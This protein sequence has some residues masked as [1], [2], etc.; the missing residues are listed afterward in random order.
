VSSGKRSELM[1][2]MAATMR[3]FMAYAVLFQDA[4][5]KSAGLNA[6]DLQCA[7]LLLAHGPATP[8][9]LAERVGLTAGGAITAL[10]DRLERAGLVHRSRDAADRRRV[11]V[12]A[13]AAALAE[14]VG[15]VYVQVGQRWAEYLSTL[16]DEQLVLAVRLF[17]AAADINRDETARLRGARRTS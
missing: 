17:R 4:V 8:G 15:P 16:D 1:A 11:V 13:D 9:E 6:T 2:D 10:I 12:T 3:D 5:A 7:G 14:R